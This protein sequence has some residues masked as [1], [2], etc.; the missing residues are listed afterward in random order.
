MDAAADLKQARRD[1]SAMRF[2]RACEIAAPWFRQA[3]DA[4]S[5]SEAAEAALVLAKARGN[6]RR[7][8]E[9][10]RW[11]H[12]A[13]LAATQAE[14]PDLACGAWIEIAR[15]HALLEQGD[16]AQLAVD[17]VLAL[18]PSLQQPD[19]LKSAYNGLTA[20]YGEMG[21][22][23]LGLQAG[24]RALGYGEASEDVA[25]RAMLRTNFLIILSMTHEQLRE[26]DPAA[27][28]QL[29][30]EAWPHLET[31]RSEALQVGTLMAVA[32][33]HRVAGALL[34]CA[35]RWEE[36]AQA[37]QA[38]T[39]V[40]AGLPAPLACLAWIESGLALRQLGRHDEARA[41]AEEAA[42]VDPSAVPPHLVVELR[43]RARICELTGRV[44][45]ALELE[46]RAYARR[47]H[48]AMAALQ[49]RAAALSARI[50]EQGLRVENLSL[51][52]RNAALQAHVRDASRMAS[53]DPL[54]GL[55]NRRG[56]ESAWQALAALPHPRALAL[57]DLDHFKRI[58]DEHSHTVGD[59]VLQEVARLMVQALRGQ[60]RVAR[61]GGEE[62]AALL[63]DLDREAAH[64]AM[65]RLRLAVRTYDWGRL[66][67]G[68]R[69]SV[70]VGVVAVQPDEALPDALARADQLLYD[71]KHGGRDRVC[72]A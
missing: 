60:D 21:L 16:A 30:H 71:A 6:Q 44:Q 18:V 48:V 72:S 15:E 39:E 62:F 46:R 20:V 10:L 12:E 35:E 57:V 26:P 41:C 25:D 42:R 59:A 7:S 70:S 11:A 38:V 19:L 64:A 4:E 61:H 17:E 28:A 47:H 40:A 58:N 27:A 68:M 52:E 33:M 43:R 31:L 8:E 55:L 1:L 66:A 65:E 13:L 53:T 34:A 32:R 14:R 2:D 63:L 36:A 22:A 50:D 56:F 5:W 29:L 45:E 67:A 51:R 37:F 23:G 54:T 49:S 9:A 24:R 69:V 3:R